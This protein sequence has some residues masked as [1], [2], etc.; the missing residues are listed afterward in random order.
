MTVISSTSLLDSAR[1]N[2]L[3]YAERAERARTAPSAEAAVHN[4]LNRVSAEDAHAALHLIRLNADNAASGFAE[5]HSLDEDRV[6]ALLRDP[7][8]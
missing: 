7:L 8:G 2:T 1:A 4:D 5:A 6:A 3:E